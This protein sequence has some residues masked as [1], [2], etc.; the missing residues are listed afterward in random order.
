MKR[1]RTS[2][3]GALLA[4][5]VVLSGLAV[6]AAAHADTGTCQ[7]GDFCMYNG[8]NRTPSNQACRNSL[9][10][11]TMGMCADKEESAWNDGMTCA[12]C[13]RIAMYRRTNFTGA[14]LEAPRGVI[15]NDLSTVK[16]NKIGSPPG[17]DGMGLTLWHRV[18]SARWY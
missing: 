2:L 9:D 10:A 4:A 12:G 1:L 16:F 3:V 5:G 15:I 11:R 18:E 6:P 7:S 8:P 17:A 13:D 14:W